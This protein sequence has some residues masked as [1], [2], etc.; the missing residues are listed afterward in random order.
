M[1]DPNT[2]TCPVTPLPIE[3]LT[4]E[5]VYKDNQVNLYWESATELNN[6]FYSVNH[7]TDGFNFAEI[8]IKQGAGTTSSTRTYDMIHRHPSSGINYYQLISSD[9]NGT[10]YDKGII[11]VLV[12]QDRIFYDQLTQQILFPENGNYNMYRSP[13]KKIAKLKNQT[14]FPKTIIRI[15]HIYKNKTDISIKFTIK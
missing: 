9:F 7:S 4:F 12:D 10:Q 3:L 15:F 6:D 11:S 1:R 5:G 14:Q 13:G 8:G 2:A